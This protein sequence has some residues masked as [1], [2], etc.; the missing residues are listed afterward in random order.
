MTETLAPSA[1]TEAADAVEAPETEGGPSAAFS[2]HLDNF[3]GPFDLLLSLIGKHK[4]DIT[5]VAL[6]RVTDEFIAHIKAAGE[7]WDL[8]QT[9]SFLLVASTL[10]DLK[11]AR[12]L[13]QGDVEDEEDL[14]LLEARDLLFAR[15]LQYRAYKQVASVL[16]QRMVTE[17]RRHPRAVGMEERFATLLPEVLIGLGLE[18]FARLAAG[19]LAPKPE[20]QLMLQHIHAPAVSVR[21]QAVHVQD[22]LRQSGTLTFRALAADAP[23]TMTRVARFLALLELFREGVV[24]FEQATALSELSIRWTGDETT[25]VDIEDEFDGAPP[26]PSP[27]PSPQEDDDDRDA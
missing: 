21:E 13:P 25:Q 15:L 16:E 19:A 14:A 23:D 10:L 22:R 5:E 26:Q 18:E 7:R 12:L 9:T 17:E 20:P 11:A 27:Q 24:A 8:E 4:L 6:S 2:V 3:E 1:G